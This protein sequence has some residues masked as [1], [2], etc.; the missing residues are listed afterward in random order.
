MF[1]DT[2]K[3]PFYLA[4]LLAI[5]L[6]A[7]CL[8]WLHNAG[9]SLSLNAYD[10][11]EWTTLHPSVRAANPSLITSLL[12]RLPLPCLGLAIAFGNIT[13]SRIV[14]IILLGLLSLALFPPLEFFTSAR[15]DPNYQ[16]LFAL[17]L[18]TFITGLVVPVFTSP[19]QKHII[20]IV[21]MIVGLIAALVGTLQA[22]SLME[23][24]KLP[25]QLGLGIVLIVLTY[26]ALIYREATHYKQ[27]L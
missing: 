13:R 8:P 11:A 18:I 22:N 1:T 3:K 23:T 12:L 26:I 9:V 16:Q 4:V 5:A 19:K 10:L 2:Q 7:Y 24:F 17:A 27:A 6:L 25:A 21:L 15:N 14:K 20:V